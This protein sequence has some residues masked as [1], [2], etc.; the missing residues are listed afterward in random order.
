M[1][2]DLILA[3]IGLGSVGMVAVGVSGLVAEALGAIFG[4]GFVAGDPSG[5]TYTKARCDYLLE[6]A[7]GAHN[8][9]EAA[10]AHHF[11]EVVEY[12]VAAG[13]LGLIG[14]GVWLLLRRRTPRAG[15][16][17]EGF[18]STVATALFTVAAAGLLLESVDM[19]AVGGESSGVGALLSGGL[20]AAVAA[21]GFVGLLPSP[22]C[23]PRG[24]LRGGTARSSGRA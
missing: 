4:R 24:R 18:T 7:P 16:L 23:S 13:V 3:A 14:L 21:V 8:C 5:V 22:G 19:T 9:A 6:Y 11:G 1:W 2:G 10:T 12:R 15:V 20:V 17:P